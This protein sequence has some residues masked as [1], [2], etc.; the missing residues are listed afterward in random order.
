MREA[1]EAW[2]LTMPAI[3]EDAGVKQGYGAKNMPQR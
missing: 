3:P 1:W 2:N